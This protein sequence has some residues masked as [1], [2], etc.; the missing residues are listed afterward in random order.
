MKAAEAF[1]HMNALPFA[2]ADAVTG[3]VPTVVL[4]PHP[5]DE[6]LGC[7]GLIAQLYAA[8]RPPFVLVIT[9]GTGSH[10]HSKT[11]PPARL[12]ALREAE[13]RDAGAALGLAAAQIGF[14]RL[15]DTA[16]PT[17]GPAAGGAELVA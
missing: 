17:T 15:T 16:A 8:A 2:S 9:D 13:M 4:A 6:S 12:C 11:Y 14:L 3:A 5:D 7:G 10:P 1:R